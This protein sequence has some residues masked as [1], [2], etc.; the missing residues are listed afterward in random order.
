MSNTGIVENRELYRPEKKRI[1]NRYFRHGCVAIAVLV[2]GMA[3][4]AVD[5]KAFFDQGMEAFR[6]GNYGSSELLFRKIIDAGDEEYID[7]AWF[8]LARSLYNKKKFE[9]SLLNSRASE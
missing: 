4:A 5:T 8:Y 9:A 3:Q 1:V 2:A 6:T 7:Q